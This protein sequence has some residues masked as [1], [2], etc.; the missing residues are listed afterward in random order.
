[1]QIAVAAV[2]V[3]EG[4]CDVVVHVVAVRDALVPAGGPVRLAAF[5]GCAGGRPPAVHL[6][7][8]LVEVAGVGRVM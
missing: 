5:D 7:L 8:V 6:E 3:A 4:A 2:R 1:M